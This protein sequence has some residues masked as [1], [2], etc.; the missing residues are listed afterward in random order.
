MSKKTT[1]DER[2][3]VI[4]GFC[5]NLDLWSRI[6]EQAAHSGVS[7]THSYLSEKLDTFHIQLEVSGTWNELAKFESALKSEYL[8]LS[9]GVVFHFYRGE[10]RPI[11]ELYLPYL[12][13]ASTLMN[14]EMIQLFTQFFSMD[15]IKIKEIS[16]QRY[17][18]GKT[19][20]PLQLITLAVWLPIDINLPELRENFMIFCEQYNVDGIFEQDRT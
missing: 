10:P 3:V 17:I 13:Q 2:L 6:L 20:V 1:K 14:Q 9:E 11:D 19:F 15:R 5:P 18:Q 7:T 4:A 8:K 16:V 12:V